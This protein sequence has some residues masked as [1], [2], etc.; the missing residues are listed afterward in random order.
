MKK[1]LPPRLKNI[2][3]RYSIKCGSFN[4]SITTLE[5]LP[6]R[7]SQYFCF[8][9]MQPNTLGC[10]RWRWII[11]P[12]QALQSNQKEKTRKPSIFSPINEI[13][14]LENMFKLLCALNRGNVFYLTK[15]LFL[16][17][18]SSTSTR[19]KICLIFVFVINLVINRD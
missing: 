7:I 3:S 14:F 5:I 2:R 10:K 17:D 11:W 15:L 1:R 13:D 8:G 6:F 4:Q 16:I 18:F 12:S 19:E 9:K